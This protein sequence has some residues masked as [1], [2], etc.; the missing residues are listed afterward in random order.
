LRKSAVE[1]NRGKK[2]LQERRRN[3]IRMFIKE[4]TSLPDYYDST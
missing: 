4:E 3:A 1:L 2:E